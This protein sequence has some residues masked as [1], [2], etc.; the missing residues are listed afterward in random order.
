[1]STDSGCGEVCT[2]LKRAVVCISQTGSGTVG[3]S[4]NGVRDDGRISST[5][6]M[7]RSY[8]VGSTFGGIGEPPS[9]WVET[10]GESLGKVPLGFPD[11]QDLYQESRVK[12]KLHVS[13]YAY[14][15]EKCVSV[16]IENLVSCENQLVF[17]STDK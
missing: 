1:M 15:V 13:V 4:T 9:W 3:A 12:E 11:N 7:I 14:K 5:S 10:E 16:K 6:S 2:I 8:T 17:H